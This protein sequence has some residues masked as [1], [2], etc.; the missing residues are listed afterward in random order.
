[1]SECVNPM[2]YKRDLIRPTIILYSRLKL[3][4]VAEEIIR[5]LVLQHNLKVCI[6]IIRIH[7]EQKW[8]LTIIAAC[9][10]KPLGS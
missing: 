10:G 2:R 9:Y 4:A 8:A 1:M 3:Y 7:I 5:M 6:N